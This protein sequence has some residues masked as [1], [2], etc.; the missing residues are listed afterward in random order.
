MLLALESACQCG[1]CFNGL[2]RIAAA[3]AHL[4]CLHPDRRAR[5]DLERWA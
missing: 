4:A 5:A 1:P 3:M 2:P